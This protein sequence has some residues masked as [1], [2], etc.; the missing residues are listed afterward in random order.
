MNK[1]AEDIEIGDLVNTDIGVRE[2]AHVRHTPRF[3]WIR[4]VGQIKARPYY[5]D[6]E[7]NTI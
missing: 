6:E 4:F 2:V 7:L 3:V 1:T 5:R